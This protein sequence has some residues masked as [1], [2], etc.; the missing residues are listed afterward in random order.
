[1]LEMLV[2]GLDGVPD[3][4]H[5]GD[6]PEEERHEDESN[7][8]TYAKSCPLDRAAAVAAS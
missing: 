2:G 4:S 8:S 6:L 5:N 1:M 3:V 7:P